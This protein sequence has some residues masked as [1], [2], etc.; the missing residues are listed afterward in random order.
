MSGA[1]C[2]SASSAHQLGP[3]GSQ[4]L[5]LKGEKKEKKKGQFRVSSIF[6]IPLA[7][8]ILFEL[9]PLYSKGNKTEIWAIRETPVKGIAFFGLILIQILLLSALSSAFLKTSILSAARV[10]QEPGSLDG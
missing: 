3:Q 7:E 1:I 2:V 5:W 4:H 8:K 9:T 10:G 6:R